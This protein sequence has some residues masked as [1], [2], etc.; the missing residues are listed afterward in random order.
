GVALLPVLMFERELRQGRL[1]CPFETGIVTGAYWL[2]RLKSRPQG[3]A[4]TAFRD[5]LQGHAAGM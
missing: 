3:A 5:W 2:T 4:M 1:V